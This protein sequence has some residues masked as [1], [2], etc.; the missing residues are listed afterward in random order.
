MKYGVPERLHSDQ[1]RNVKSGVI[2]EVC[3]MYGFKKS[4]TTPYHPTGNAV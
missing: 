2:A 3:Q 4:C 1:G